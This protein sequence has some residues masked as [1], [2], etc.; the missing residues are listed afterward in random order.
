M[1][2]ARMQFTSQIASPPEL[3]FDL[4]ADMP[5]Y[6]RWL[7]DSTVFGGTVKVA[8]YPVR[9]GT[10]YLDAGPVEKPGKVT[11]SDPPKHI[12]FHHTVVVRQALLKDRHRRSHSL[13]IHAERRRDICSSRT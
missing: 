8:P 11:E 4:V 5:N 9:V 2:I 1:S 7:P 12:G 10:T 3:I 6:G 13:H